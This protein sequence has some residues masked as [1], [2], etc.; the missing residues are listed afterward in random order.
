VSQKLFSRNLLIREYI[1]VA[2]VKDEGLKYSIFKE[3]RQNT[4][5]K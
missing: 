2:K 4:T 3:A 5:V 1:K